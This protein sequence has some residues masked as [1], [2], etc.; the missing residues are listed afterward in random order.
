MNY[1]Q[2]FWFV[3]FL[4]LKKIIIEEILFQSIIFLISEK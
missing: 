3:K 4:K 1:I 2:F